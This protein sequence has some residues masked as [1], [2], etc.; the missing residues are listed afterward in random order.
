MD[1]D[2]E[3]A[4]IGYDSGVIQDSRLDVIGMAWELGNV[5]YILQIG[6]YIISTVTLIHHQPQAHGCLL[7]LR[8][9]EV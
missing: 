8:P 9:R 3:Y 5:L 1:T 4:W 7:C 6:I 2:F